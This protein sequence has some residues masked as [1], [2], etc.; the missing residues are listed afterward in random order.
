MMAKRKSTTKTYFT[1]VKTVL[2]YWADS[3]WLGMHSPLATPYFLGAQLHGAAATTEARGA[4]LHAA[5]EQTLETLWRGPLPVAAEA[6]MAAVD[7][8]EEEQG[9]GDRYDCLILELNYL[10]RVFRPA[11]KSQAEIYNDIL[12]ISRPTHDRHLAQAVERLGTILLQRVRP[13]IHPEQ[14]QLTEA[15]V[16]CLF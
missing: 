1:H 10:K 11:P 16:G 2:E 3:T 15:L 9:R 13:V 7:A 8:E 5:I 6:M 4:I 14:P 12:H